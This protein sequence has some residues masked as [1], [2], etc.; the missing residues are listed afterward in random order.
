[1]VELCWLVSLC[2]LGF[3]PVIV[4]WVFW[5]LNTLRTT[6]LCYLE[7]VHVAVVLG[8]LAGLKKDPAS[9]EK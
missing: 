5:P 7:D 1:M 9:L 8:L 6:R 2:I 3:V 4:D